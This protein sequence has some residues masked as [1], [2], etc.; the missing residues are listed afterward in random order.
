M[1]RVLLA[2]SSL[3]VRQSLASLGLSESSPVE[4]VGVLVSGEGGGVSGLGVPV[5][6]GFESLEVAVADR[7]AEGL[8][9]CLPQAMRERIDDLMTRGGRLGLTCRYLPPVG[10]QLA[11]LVSVSGRCGGGSVDAES[12][13]GRRGRPLDEGA[14]RG[15]LGGQTVLITGAAGSIGSEL[16]RIAC[17]YEPSL[18]VLADR[19][20]NG[21]FQLDAELGR[22]FPDV[23]RRVQIHD[24][25]HR[26]A[27]EALF[28]RYRPDVVLHAAAH[29]HVPL[30]EDH[31][32]AAVEN[33]F[34]GT[35]W[36]VDAAVAAGVGRLVM[37]ST[38]KAVNPSSIMGASKRL[39][40]L[41]IQYASR[42]SETTLAM[43]RFGN[44]LG[45]ACSVLP[46][47]SEQLAHGGPITV[48]HP[49][50][51]RYFMTI[52]EAAGLVL[53]A[54]GYARGGEVF[55]LDMGDPVRI[56]DLAERYLRQHG[57]EPGVDMSVRITGPRP[58]EKLFEEL[59]YRS[60]A[61]TPTEH[62]SIRI[63][64]TTPPEPARI[65]QLLATFDR[66]RDAGGGGPWEGT[67]PDAVA[68]ALRSA[69]PEM[70]TA[71]SAAG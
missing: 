19:S 52:P 33:N 6:G 48:T 27:N 1:R 36:V 71:V 21:L 43:V 47:W 22:L 56:L 30:M 50:M 9:V 70:V 51:T 25:T 44:V 60:E 62:P 16:A 69:I 5:C 40:E 29:K 12:L 10:D 20:E 15:T 7:S 24:V 46:I 14:L 67:N 35:R 32:T 64:E 8:L 63:W 17:R 53:Q 4:V 41:Y 54:A 13:I 45:S 38:D 61:M 18:I 65:Q 34:Y 28:A 3:A 31:P 55:L 59:A 66:L 37:I 58:G 23:S 2:G 49:E 11:G 57:L 68:T 39:A 26:H 42:R